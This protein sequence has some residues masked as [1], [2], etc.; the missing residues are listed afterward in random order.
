MTLF[1]HIVLSALLQPSASRQLGFSKDILRDLTGRIFDLGVALDVDIHVDLDVLAS[2]MKLEEQ[3][4]DPEEEEDDDELPALAGEENGKEKKWDIVNL[5]ETCPACGEGINFEDVESACCSR[6]HEW[7]VSSSH[8]LHKKS[9]LTSR[10]RFQPDRCSITFQVISKAQCR[11]C[12]QCARP[13]I[14][15]PSSRFSGPSSTVR[16]KPLPGLYEVGYAVKP[17]RTEEDNMVLDVPLPRDPNGPAMNA[18]ASHGSQPPS[19]SSTVHDV[20]M[21][22]EADSDDDVQVTLDNRTG[23]PA[24]GLAM[25]DDDTEDDGVFVSVEVKQ[26]TSDAELAGPRLTTDG[27]A[28]PWLMDELLEAAGCCLYCGG[29]FALTL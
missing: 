18:T 8:V 23:A 7:G 24:A 17:E 21:R 5:G 11:R 1:T 3:M 27:H 28:S 20:D 15:P 29:R 10:R 6:G 2:V 12:V 19:P 9:R 14:L 22:D 4:S 26:E 13:A 16:L 25:Q